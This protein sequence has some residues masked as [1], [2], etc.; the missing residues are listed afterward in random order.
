MHTYT[1]EHVEHATNSTILLTLR[2]KEEGSYFSFLPG[3]YAAI[4][5]KH[6]LRPS[7]TRCFSIVSSP[8]EQTKLQFAMREKG[9]YTKKLATLEAGDTITVRGPFGGFVVDPLRDSSVV[10]LAGGIGITPFISMIRYFTAVQSTMPITLICGCQSQGD[11]PFIQ[12][13]RILQ[14][15]NPYLHVVFVVSE[16]PTDLL[17]DQTV[18]VGRVNEEVIT[19]VIENKY[20]DNTFFTCGP[21]PFMRALVAVLSAKNVPN[22]KIITEAFAQG[23]H[24]QT[25]KVQSWPY[26]MYAL[27]AIGLV[28][29]SFIVIA[30]DFFKNLPANNM[31]SNDVNGTQSPLLAN[32]RQADLD[33]M[34]NTM[35]SNTNGAPDTPSVIAAYAAVDAANRAIAAQ[36]NTPVAPSTRTNNSTS[37]T[38]VSPTTVAT[39][40]KQC[41][42]TQSGK[43]VCV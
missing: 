6:G 34:V 42:T 21:P 2:P 12:E 23:S 30:N 18:I 13:L 9:F 7:A 41:T 8:T 33:N 20:D 38:T 14:H 22:Q 32:K 1:V 10:L 29:T 40:Q 27:G 19:T 35:A 16:G 26:N 4:S 25:G 11:I 43:T 5:F 28:V 15:Q 39:P 3:Q 36:N 31:I 37:T 17:S 24:R